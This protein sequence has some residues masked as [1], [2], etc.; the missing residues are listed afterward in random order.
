MKIAQ[1]APLYEAVPPKLY[2]GTERVVAHLCDALV[3]QGHDVTLFAAADANTRAQVPVEARVGSG[4]VVIELRLL[5]PT[6]V[7]IGQAQSA[8]VT[9]RADWEGIGLIIL[10]GLIGAFLT[11]G[12]MRM[13]LRRRRA[14]NTDAA[15]EEDSTAAEETASA[16][17]AAAAGDAGE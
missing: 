12:V 8:D 17:N 6:G 1:I 11:L 14:K 4:D 16:E 5:S 9:V 15:A 7:A 10:G 3:D 2:G 13:V